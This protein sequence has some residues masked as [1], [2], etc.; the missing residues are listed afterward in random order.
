MLS[1]AMAGSV[2][3]VKNR[4]SQARS[5]SYIK[6]LG[7]AMAASNMDKKFGKVRPCGFGVMQMDKQTYRSQFFAPLREAK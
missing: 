7:P 5:I 4:P 2:F 1:A 6:N 3:Y